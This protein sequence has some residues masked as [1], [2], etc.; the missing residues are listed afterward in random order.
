LAF[1]LARHGAPQIFAR[2]TSW[3][4]PLLVTVTS[5]CAIGALVALWCGRFRWARAAAIGQVTCILVGWGLAQQPY[6]VVPDL[7][8]VGTATDPKTL[9]LLKSALLAGAVVLLPSFV[10]LFYVFKRR[11]I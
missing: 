8:F 2:L 1:L 11:P 10:Y 6:I 9:Y 4:A 5:A 7:T 3:W